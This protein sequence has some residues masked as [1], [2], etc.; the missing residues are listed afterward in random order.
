MLAVDEKSQMQAIDRAAPILPITPT[1][2]ARMTHEYVRQ[3]AHLPVRRARLSTGSVI[4]QR[5]RRHPA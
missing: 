3:V 2:P 4:A 1:T 5:Y